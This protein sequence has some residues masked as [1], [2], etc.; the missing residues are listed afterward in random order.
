VVDRD[1]PVTVAVEGE[2]DLRVTVAHLRLEALRKER[3]DARVDVDAIRLGADGHH[4]R[5]QPP[6]HARRH[7]MGRPVRAVDRD[8]HA[9]EVEREAAAQVIDVV[10]LGAVVDVE[11]SDVLAVRARRGVL[12]RE[13]ALD[14][15]L[16]RV[17]ELGPLRGEE[18]D[19]V[20]LVRVVGGGEH[21][22]ALRVQPA[23]EE[24][25]PGGRQHADRVALAA[26]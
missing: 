5:P 8:R 20:V 13:P 16:P 2:A 17:G 12:R 14:L 6:E 21:D 26:R 3:A 10:L 4:A 11:P 18:L 19:A 23:R 25:D 15:V 22:P 24:R 9:G 1:Q 7:A